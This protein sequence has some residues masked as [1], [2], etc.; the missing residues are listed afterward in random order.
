[1]VS[2]FILDEALIGGEEIKKI[3]KAHKFSKILLRNRVDEK[4]TNTYKIKNFYSTPNLKSFRATKTQG[5]HLSFFHNKL[6]SKIPLLNTTINK[7]V[8]AHDLKEILKANRNFKPQYFVISPIFQTNTHIEKKALSR[9]ELFKIIN[10]TTFDN[11]ILLG[12]MNLKKMKQIQRLD[13]KKKIK[14]FA[15]INGFLEIKKL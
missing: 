13:S 2:F 8:A 5:M 10:K 14:G 4:F 6:I 11:F 12:G 15:G 7:T 3:L 1:M 9:I